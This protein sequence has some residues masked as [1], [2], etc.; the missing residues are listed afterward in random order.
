[1]SLMNYIYLSVVL[2][3][4]RRGHRAGAPQ[5]DHRLHGRR[6]D[7]QRRQPRLRHLRPDARPLD[8]Q[9]IAL[10]VMIVAAAEVVLSPAIIMA[11]FRACRSASVDGREPAE[12]VEGATGVTL[13]HCPCG[14]GTEGAA[15][16]HQADGIACSRLAAHALPAARCR[17]AAARRPPHQL[18]RP[19]A[20]D[21]SVWASFGVGAAAI[22]VE[23]LAKPADE[24]AVTRT[25]YSWVPHDPSTSTRGSGWTSCPSRSCC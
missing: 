24:R 3:L 20:R 1:M 10:F 9:A 15:T 5:R 18:L 11:I 19:G 2:F 6:A 13:H 17:P 14:P 16:V 12:A 25:L 22:F 21:R 7:A 8:G 4:A 23:M